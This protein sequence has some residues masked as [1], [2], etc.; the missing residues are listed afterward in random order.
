[1]PDFTVIK[2]GTDTS[3]RPILMTAYMARVW[4]QILDDPAVQPFADRLTIVQGAFM[5]RAGGG[6][7]ASAGVHDKAGCLDVRTWNLNA[8]ELE[9]FIRATRRHGFPFWRRDQRHGMDPHAHGILGTDHPL[10]SGA[11]YQWRQYLDGRNGLANNAPDYEW[12]PSPLVTTPPEADDMP[13]SPEELTKIVREAVAKEFAALDEQ[14][15]DLEDQVNKSR[16][17]MRN[18][19]ANIRTI[20]NERLGEDETTQLIGHLDPS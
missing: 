11:A 1:M 17:Q 4:Q 2:Y 9:G 20:L 5:E 14:L 8:T 13:Y 3:G 18:Q 12:R 7:S 15:D 19:F 6:A 16:Q 10:D